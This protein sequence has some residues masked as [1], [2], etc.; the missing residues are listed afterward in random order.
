MKAE[1]IAAVATGVTKKWA[2]QRKAEERSTKARSRREYMYSDR[3]AHTEV[4]PQI[5]P[6]A[7]T[8]V[9]GARRL[10]V[11]QRQLFYAAR[12]EF[13]G[14][15]G[16]EITWENFKTV[17]RKYLQRPETESWKITR[18]PRGMFWEPHT[19]REVPVGTIRIDGYLSEMAQP[20][21][22]T[23]D[24]AFAAKFPTCGPVNRFQAILYIEK[25]GFNPLFREVQLAER[26]DIAIMSCKG[27][28]VI[29]ARKLV[30]RLCHERG[31]PLLVLHDFDKYGFSI[32]Q[33]ISKVS[34]AAEEADR[35]VYKFQNKINVVDL[36]L[37]LEDVKKW[38]LKPERCTF[39]GTFDGGCHITQDEKDYLRGGQRV[40]LNA[41]ASEAFITFVEE[42]LRWA[43]IKK[44]FVPDDQ[45]LK[46]AFQRAHLIAEMNAMVKNAREAAEE[47]ASA[48]KVPKTL[49]SKIRNGLRTNPE[50]PWDTVLYE[51]V[52]ESIN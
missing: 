50:K 41:F 32:C 45:T 22:S 44:K 21:D 31:I 37:R 8:F 3:I 30:D 51:I 42:K 18:D 43:G 5:L 47:A 10:S 48:L 35:V 15:T 1:D 36:G 49:R 23:P 4:S 2:K 33:C 7:Y 19:R 16:R 29:A 52:S 28:S 34:W 26:F 38:G 20:P 25:E 24:F 46:A 13:L 6:K 11:S 12:D 40:E 9:A 14:L 39:S 27:Q 17:L